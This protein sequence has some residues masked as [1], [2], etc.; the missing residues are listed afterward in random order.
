[1]KNIQI[2]GTEL[3]REIFQRLGPSFIRFQDWYV[4]E[5]FV[6]PS[7]LV[8]N[9]RRDGFEETK[10]WKRMRKELGVLIKEL[11]R[12]AYSISNKGQLSLDALEARVAEK[13]DEIASLRQSGFKKVERVINLSSDIAKTQKFI[14]KAAKNADLPTAASLQALGAEL[15]DIQSEAIRKIGASKPTADV[16]R[17][18]QESRDELLKELLSIFESELPPTCAVAVR[19]LLRKQYGLT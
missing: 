6:S 19:D 5:I 11:K 9:A 10:E 12:E 18:Q 15:T 1:M 8:P 4:G 13:R 16:E 3:V 14:A 2:D 7:F 17:I